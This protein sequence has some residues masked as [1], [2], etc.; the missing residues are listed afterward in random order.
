[1]SEQPYK[2]RP[3]SIGEQAIAYLGTK[4]R[5]SARDLADGI[6]CEHGSLHASLNM[7]VLHGLVF[8]EAEGG[9][10]FY[11]LGE[12]ADVTTIADRAPV[13]REKTESRFECGVFS[14]GRLVLEIGQ[15]VFTF[16]KAERDRLTGFLTG[17]RA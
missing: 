1:M 17:V 2:P 8:R 10:T 9:V 7:A 16:T 13:E 15:E 4:G 3:G 14:D 12:K 11:S 5:T 6:E